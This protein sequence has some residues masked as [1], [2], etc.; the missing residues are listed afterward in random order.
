MV[1]FTTNFEHTRFDG[2]AGKKGAIANRKAESFML[3][4]AQLNF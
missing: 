4:R 2:G 3:T 1:R